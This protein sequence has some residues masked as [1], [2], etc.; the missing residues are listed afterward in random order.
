MGRGRAGLPGAATLQSTLQGR[1]CPCGQRK[2]V[3]ISN[4]TRL[5]HLRRFGYWMDEGIRLPGT[6]LRIGLDPIIGLVPGLGDALGALLGTAIL[7]EAVRRRTPRSTLVRMIGNIALDA[8][9]GAVPLLG[10]LFDA[11]WKA[12]LKNL[13]LLERHLTEPS[14]AKRADRLFL[15]VLGGLLLLLCAA[16]VVGGAILTALVFQGLTQRP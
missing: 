7:L 1:R 10:D 9:L 15:A 13:A 4:D 3:P 5:D 14:R 6:R 2:D 12:N 16:L 11:A 8:L